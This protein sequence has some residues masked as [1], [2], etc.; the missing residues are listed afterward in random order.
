[1]YRT[2][3]AR[4]SAAAGRKVKGLAGGRGGEAVMGRYELLEIPLMDSAGR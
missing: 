3:G 2:D 1:V 4:R